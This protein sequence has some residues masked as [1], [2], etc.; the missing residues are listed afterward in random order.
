MQ[1]AEPQFDVGV[2]VG[3]FQVHALHDGHRDLIQ[4]VCE[5][6]DKV[7]IVL[8]LSPLVVTSNN[9]LDFQSREQ[10]IHEFF[11]DVIVAY[12]KDQPDDALW[13]KS[14]D[15]VIKDLITP[16]QS[17]VL[18]GSRD[19]FIRHYSGKHQTREL[20]PEDAS[21]YSGTA[22]RKMIA[23]S[24]TRRTAD[25]RAG[26]AWAASSRFPTAF[27]TVDVAILDHDNE[28]L[29]L[30]RKPNERLYRFVGGF[31]DPRSDSLEHD[32]RREVME[33]TGVSVEDIRY[34][35]S[36][37]VDDWRYRSE[38]DCIKTAL[39]TAYYVHGPARA[40]DDI[41]EVKWFPFGWSFVNPDLDKQIV[42]EH[43][44]LMK[45][46]RA[47]IIHHNPKESMR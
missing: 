16:A 4:H 28:R 3:R 11:P 8:G 17:V 24:S 1:T 42:P 30:G 44:S 34:V 5:K 19:S 22:I 39:F 45:M 33:E 27:Q 37:V 25:F 15:G 23:R 38:V 40:G 14:L 10:M 18:Y 20:V 9:P 26:V 6:H 41:E 31:S 29:L 2:I 35:G 12:I 32:A 47:H 13:S 43:V 21:F 36:T 7:I 46:L